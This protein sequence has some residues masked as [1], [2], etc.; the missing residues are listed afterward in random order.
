MKKITLL[1]AT[2]LMGL[3]VANATVDKTITVERT[4][5]RFSFDEPIAFTERGIEFF[6][7]PNGDF[8]FNT[9]PDDTQGQYY[10]RGAGKRTTGE[11]SAERRPVNFGVLIEQDSFGRIRRVGNVFIN[12][13]FNDRVTRIGTVFMRYD[14]FNLTQIGGMRIV[15]DRRGNIV[16]MI[17]SVK[18]NS[19][20]Y[21]GP[22]QNHNNW[23]ND[24]DYSYNSSND[25]YYY[26]ADGTR[27]K[28]EEEEKK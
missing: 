22:T 9:R 14:R 15:Y 6:V 13:D 2:A 26:R 5:T 11:A 1:V 18:R 17:G 3:N 10:F 19:G 25:Y 23:D 21:Y 24:H 28:I 8:D 20:Y 7:F 4:M 27:A 12:Y 16:E